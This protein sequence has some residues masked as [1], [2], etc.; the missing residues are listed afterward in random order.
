[1]A[2]PATTTTTTRR[3]GQWLG[4]QRGGGKGW[5][6]GFRRLRLC[7]F[8]VV[9]L[10]LSEFFPFALPFLFSTQPSTVRKLLEGWT[11]AHGAVGVAMGACGWRWGGAV[12]NHLYVSAR[13][14]LSVKIKRRTLCRTAGRSL[15]INKIKAV[16]GSFGGKSVRK[17]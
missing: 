14:R 11:A 10:S 17:S 3:R 13:V 7:N 2:G 6:L 16:P 9:R 12:V 8:F 4:V 5:W 15:K 1:M